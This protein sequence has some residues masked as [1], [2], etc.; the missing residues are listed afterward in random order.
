MI[1]LPKVPFQ[2]PIQSDSGQGFGFLNVTIFDEE[3][4]EPSQE[5][6]FFP[7]L[8][9]LSKVLT[10]CTDD[11]ITA[12]SFAEFESDDMQ[13]TVIR[14]LDGKGSHVPKYWYNQ[15]MSTLG[16]L[17]K[18]HG[19]RNVI[20][21]VEAPFWKLELHVLV[22]VWPWEWFPP[23]YINVPLMSNFIVRI[24]EQFED[25]FDAVEGLSTEL[26]NVVR[27]LLDRPPDERFTTLDA[28]FEIGGYRFRL[29]VGGFRPFTNR[30]AYN[31]LFTWARF[32]RYLAEATEYDNPHT[33][34][35]LDV[36]SLSQEPAVV[37]R[38]WF[39]AERTG[40]AVDS[41]ESDDSSELGTPRGNVS[42]IASGSTR[43]NASDVAFRGPS[44]GN[45]RVEVVS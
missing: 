16:G 24:Q 42:A 28:S 23:L 21:K 34:D 2:V 30:Q 19:L 27:Q 38:G 29:A 11:Y 41:G 5:A 7:L 3:R 43:T 26:L 32:T 13:S 22:T 33:F 20:S 25:E 44:R 10:D 4:G 37:A 35:I 40:E 39:K 9:K 6:T 8:G 15:L 14:M 18:R 31:V 17:F 1:R 45:E 36:G 12:I